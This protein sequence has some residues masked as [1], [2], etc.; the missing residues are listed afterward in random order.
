M[1]ANEEQKK[2]I[3][4]F[5]AN[6]FI[7]APWG[8]RFSIN[9]ALDQRFLPWQKKEKLYR[10]Y[11]LQR[12]HLTENLFLITHPETT[13]DADLIAEREQ[14]GAQLELEKM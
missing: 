2:N 4:I 5:Y 10:P 12:N 7:D 8:H 3:E 9:A 1:N 6:I 14:R 11:P 13:L